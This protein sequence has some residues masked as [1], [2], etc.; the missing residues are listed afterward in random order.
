MVNLGN[1]V[2]SAR[3]YLWSLVNNQ[4]LQMHFRIQILSVYASLGIF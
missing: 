4:A 2:G 1:S 3:Q